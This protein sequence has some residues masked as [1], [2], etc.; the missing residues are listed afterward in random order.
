LI[1]THLPGR[2]EGQVKNRYYSSIKKRLESNGVLSHTSS[3]STVSE[4]V[5][6]FPTSPQVEEPKFDFGFEFD[7]NM[8]NQCATFNQEP[9][10]KS[11]NQVYMISK[12]PYAFEED[13][14]SDDTTTQGII[15]QHETPFRVND[16]TSVISYELAQ[17]SD[18][19]LP[20]IEND[21]QIDD[22]LQK[23]TNY[24]LD[25]TSSPASDVDSYFSD[26]LKSQKRDATFSS[27][28][29]SAEK[30]ALLAKRKAYLELALAKTLKEMKSF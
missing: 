23:V 1:A 20:T 15:S 18:F 22:V 12:G 27:E 8:M 13:T 25:N 17:Q 2:T 7:A 24:F 30:M 11:T 14:H 16:P 9:V 29:N 3:A 21:N 28:A 5:S 26:D 19:F 10:M 4:T 6:S